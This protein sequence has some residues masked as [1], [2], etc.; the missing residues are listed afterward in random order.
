MESD[1]TRFE[2][3]AAPSPL[4]VLGNLRQYVNNSLTQ[5]EPRRIIGTNK[6]WLLSFGD[7]CA[8]LVEFL[9]FSKDGDDWLPPR[10]D[11][12]DETPY[13]NPENL[14]L[15]DVEKELEALMIQ[16]P[17]EEKR[18]A[19]VHFTFEPGLTA[20]EK[21]L[22]S[23]DYRKSLSSRAADLTKSEEHP[24]YA[25]LGT[26][27]DMHDEL[28]G[29]A[30][31]CQI[32]C[33]PS[34]G[35]YYLECLQGLAAGRQSEE[36]QT[37][38]A[39]EA[40]S[41]KSSF[42]DVREAYYFFGIDDPR[43]HDDDNIV[44]TFQARLADAPR[45]EA[46]LRRALLIIGQDRSSARIEHI[47]TNAVNTYEQ[48][49]TWLN[50]TEDMTNEFLISMFTVK[51]NENPN[52]KDLARKAVGLI[53]E[54]R[55]DQ[56]L[57]A[58]LDTGELGETEMDIGQAYNRLGI[59]DRRIDD[60]VILS[61]YTV[62]AHDQ[63]SQ[64]HDLKRALAAIS[65]SKGGSSSFDDVLG[66][67]FRVPRTDEQ[68][69]SEPV[70]LGNIGNTC[71]LN[72]LLQFYFTIKPLRDLVLNF[73]DYKMPVDTFAASRKQV[74]SRK[75]SRKEIER[76]QKFVEE[77][78]RLFNN[79]IE[80]PKA[81]VIPEQELARLTLLSSSHEETLTIR[82]QS[83]LSTTRPSLSDVHMQTEQG[84]LPTKALA[85]EPKELPKDNEMVDNTSPLRS[86]TG[87][88]PGADND[89]SSEGTL[90]D[91]T[92]PTKNYMKLNNPFTSPP[93][94]SKSGDE[95][96]H[97]PRDDAM[98]ISGQK[99]EILVQSPTQMTASSL[100]QTQLGD[101]E[102]LKRD[103]S[104]I[105][106][107]QAP[108]F[109]PPIRP[110]PV[111]PRK[112]IDDEKKAMQEEVEM[113]A[114]QDV[115]EV[116]ANVLF[117]LQCAIKPDYV[118]AS[119]EQI[120]AVK[121]LFFAKQTSYTTNDKGE[122]RSKEEFTSNIIVDVASGPRD[123]Y[124]ALDG[125]FDVQEV[126]VGGKMEPQYTTISQ[127]PP[128]LQI[129]VQRAQ[130]DPEKK[131]SF[132]SNH[133][134]EL[135][136]LIYLDRY[137]D[138]PK[139]KDLASRRQDCWQWKKELARLELQRVKLANTKLGIDLPDALDAA[140][141][142]IERCTK[143]A[144]PDPIEIEPQVIESLKQAAAEARA[145]LEA[146]DARI[147]H[148]SASISS[149]FSDL[150]KLPY[151]LHSVFI[152]RGQVSSGHYWIYIY[153]FV[154]SKWRK[155]NDEYV[156]DVADPQKEIF[157]VHSD[158]R[159]ATP[160]FLVYVREGMEDQLVNAVCRNIAKTQREE[161]PDVRMVDYDAER[162]AQMSKWARDEESTVPLDNKESEQIYRAEPDMP[163]QNW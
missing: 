82:R 141:Q 2:G 65:R 114:Q 73:E 99:D 1:P 104:M 27:E 22:G 133:H 54:K 100:S 51:I 64:L 4:V 148:L 33:D 32:S 78:R 45:Q 105:D 124:A 47:A 11:R 23:H 77:L 39:I 5:P 85:A 12:T 119:G 110:P 158:A 161:V 55:N 107:S 157:E 61:A 152:H 143:I 98:E 26:T 44:G 17:D 147:G 94:S 93:A 90:V 21:M 59:S 136:D 40:S 71:Y 72:S 53:A 142:Y 43:T 128:V 14:L 50:A 69:A 154:L 130:F 122:I 87:A 125:A 91:A 102:P 15:D 56:T 38:A 62:L 118:D 48:A 144:M 67:E 132:K 86:S 25:G 138:A 116:I 108:E 150:R 75:V 6:K 41:G 149:Q 20:I 112:V 49:L 60:A 37:K 109:G 83:I 74:G 159:P 123:V 13:E 10:P 31:D 3:H 146:L 129:L 70:G 162:S 18:M 34:N 68:L 120:D 117:Q 84:P 42:K 135:K 137:M 8:E 113:G 52:D 16:Q 57:K 66:P 80:S 19:K 92:L 7:P 103:V 139:D 134:L 76:A 131:Q 35:P 36:L 153:D 155:Y 115:T 46:E 29:F 121:Q 101:G 58:W 79:M 95:E 151:R 63:P 127:L 140:A 24:W 111:P 89:A 30:Y 97:P 126:E 106:V 81:Q 96:N 156:T 88:Q 28:L 160:Y 9:G 163:P 145:D